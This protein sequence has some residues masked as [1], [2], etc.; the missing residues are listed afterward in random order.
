MFK[1]HRAIGLLFKNSDKSAYFCNYCPHY[2]TSAGEKNI[3]QGRA[4]A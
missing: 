1:N 4:A 3:Y 2:G